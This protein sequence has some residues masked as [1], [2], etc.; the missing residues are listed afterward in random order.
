M[1]I[2]HKLE[3]GVGEDEA[4]FAG[5]A[6]VLDA[7]RDESC[8]PHP[9]SRSGQHVLRRIDA[10]DLGVRKSLRE[11]FGAGSRTAAEI[12][13]GWRIVSRKLE[14]EIASGARALALKLQVKGRV[15]I[16]HG[17][18]LALS[19]SCAAETFLRSVVIN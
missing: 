6:P 16:A 11:Q 14:Q 5:W 3:H 12:V 8:A 7:L 4:G 9:L 19:R 1:V 17:V 13:N 2:G 10:D 18:A 15:P